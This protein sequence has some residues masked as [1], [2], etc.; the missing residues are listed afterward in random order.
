MVPKK[1][2]AEQCQPIEQNYIFGLMTEECKNR[3]NDHIKKQ[4]EA[5]NQGIRYESDCDIDEP[6][7]IDL[8][9]GLWKSIKK[10]GIIIVDVTGF[11]PNVMYELG[12]ALT[13]KEHVIIICDEEV[14]NMKEI[15][16]NISHLNIIFY[17]INNMAELGTKLVQSITKV[18][19]EISTI[20]PVSEF[21]V[22]ETENIMKTAK[23]LRKKKQWDAALALFERMKKLEPENCEV[24]MQW[25]ITFKFKGDFENAFKMLNQASTLA[26]NNYQRSHIFTEIA[27][28]HEK[29][30]KD[31]EALYFFQKAEEADNSND[32][33]YRRW[34]L[35]QFRSSASDC[36][37][38][39]IFI[40]RLF[41]HKCSL[42]L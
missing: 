24:D 27:F 4:I 33:L 2:F 37:Q 14:K 6:G 39:F 22:Q 5:I 26:S 21:E 12:L 13:I 3:F 41:C 34:A 19:R 23:N 30:G 32:K 10:A 17:N 35:S 16:F 7:E 15:P 25:G 9:D 42:F 20:F 8:M 28:L 40:R 31:T 29:I 11:C 38:N 18:L 36:V 1:F